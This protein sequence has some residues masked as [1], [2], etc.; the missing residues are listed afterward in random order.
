M[1]AS[2]KWLA[3]FFALLLKKYFF[4]LEDIN[5]E[6]KKKSTFPVVMRLAP[7]NGRALLNQSLTTDIKNFSEKAP[8]KSAP[9]KC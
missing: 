7:E 2:K 3:V 8:Q 9:K 6:K 4:S 5:S 1:R